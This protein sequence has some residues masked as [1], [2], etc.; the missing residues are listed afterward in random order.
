MKS[1][2]SHDVGLSGFGKDEERAPSENA[3]NEQG[4]SLRVM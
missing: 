2:Q 3:R 4:Q 1:R